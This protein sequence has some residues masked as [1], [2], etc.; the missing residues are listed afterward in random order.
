V[1]P[2]EDLVIGL[3]ITP[4][5]SKLKRL[6][7]GE[8]FAAAPLGTTYGPWTPR[9]LFFNENPSE[10]NPELFLPMPC[11]PAAVLGNRQ[12]WQRGRF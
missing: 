3:G 1:T 9:G 6:A 4:G 7:M 11:W 10:L 12:G 8:F 2:H 5:F